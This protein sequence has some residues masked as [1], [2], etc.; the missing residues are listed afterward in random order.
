MRIG[1]KILLGCLAVPFVLVLFLLVLMLAFRAAPLPS[2]EGVAVNQEDPIG[3]ITPE[4]LASE[5]LTI[6]RAAAVRAVP[7]TINLEEGTFTIKPAPAGTSIRVEGNYDRGLYELTTELTRNDD[8]SPA[9]SI[10]FLPKYSMLR[11]VL[12]HGFVHM[13]EGENAITI[14]IP[15]DLTHRSE[16]SRCQGSVTAPARRSGAEQR[17]A[18]AAHGR[19]QCL[20]RRAE[21]RGDG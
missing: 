6:D 7:V 20:R 2:S 9:Y 4:M 3:G 14:H 8:G 17:G 5:G 1:W 16:R 15:R 10:S 11:R 19:A 13:E 12:S 18:L 21:P